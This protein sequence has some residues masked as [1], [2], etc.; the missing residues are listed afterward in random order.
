MRFFGVVLFICLWSAFFSH[1][2]SSVTSKISC[3][4]DQTLFQKRTNTIDTITN[5]SNI[6]VNQAVSFSTVGF[7]PANMRRFGN[8]KLAYSFYGGK[9]W[10]IQEYMGLGFIGDI[11]SDLNGAHLLGISI[12]SNY[13]PLKTDISPYAGA[14]IGLAF[15]RG[16]SK[17]AFGF[18]LGTSLGVIFFRSA[19]VQLSMQFKAA[20][21]LDKLPAGYP[22]SLQAR[23]GLLF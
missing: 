2:F 19:T 22:G 6:A 20:I 21:L 14:D 1:C 23:L 17:N 13:Y 10:L 5:K 4:N 18:S 11:T 16:D 8:D 9:F 7:G 15:A 3:K 12:A